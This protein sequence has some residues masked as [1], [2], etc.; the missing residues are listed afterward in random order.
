M[1][2]NGKGGEDM[3]RECT[4]VRLSEW[5]RNFLW[6]NAR[7]DERAAANAARCDTSLIMDKLFILY[8]SIM[9]TVYT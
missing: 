7:C 5:T 3:A 6:T 4:S 1:N 2:T 8:D 9:L